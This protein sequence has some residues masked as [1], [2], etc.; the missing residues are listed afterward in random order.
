MILWTQRGM[1]PRPSDYESAALTD[2]AM[3]PTTALFSHQRCKDTQKF[4][5]HNSQLRVFYEK[6]LFLLAARHR[7]QADSALAPWRGGI[8]CL[9]SRWLSLIVV[10][11]RRPSP[12]W[13][14]L[15]LWRKSSP[16]KGMLCAKK[17]PI[18]HTLYICNKKIAVERKKNAVPVLWIGIY[19]YLCTRFGSVPLVVIDQIE[20][21][22]NARSKKWK[23]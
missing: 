15:M 7:V 3:G 18:C 21:S 14:Y 19:Y 17:M 8:S 6:S 1:I 4:T 23:F 2:W 10:V 9:E 16:C 20:G 5:I 12:A 13:W 22:L 11:C